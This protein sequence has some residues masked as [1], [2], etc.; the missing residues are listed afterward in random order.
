MG[1]TGAGH[2]GT[3]GLRRRR[4]SGSRNISGRGL[5]GVTEFERSSDRNAMGRA[6]GGYTAELICKR[7]IESYRHG[8]VPEAARS[9]RKEART[10]EDIDSVASSGSRLVVDLLPALGAEDSLRSCYGRHHRPRSS[11]WTPFRIAAPA[12]IAFH[13]TAVL[14]SRHKMRMRFHNL[15]GYIK[16]GENTATTE[17]MRKGWLC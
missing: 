2:I 6:G 8:R 4:K 11:T 14:Y 10:D 16:A 9:C 5:V 13:P 15:D 7:T 12:C 3:G 1:W 17:I